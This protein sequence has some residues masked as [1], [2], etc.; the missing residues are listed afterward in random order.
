MRRISVAS[1]DIAF[2]ER[3]FADPRISRLLARAKGSSSESRVTVELSPD[4]VECIAEALTDLLCAKGLD[5]RDEPNSLGHRVE[6]L[7]D[8]FNPYDEL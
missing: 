1:A 7:I 5:E 8:L 6:A 3:E 4:D 2:L